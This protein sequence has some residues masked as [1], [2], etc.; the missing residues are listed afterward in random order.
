MKRSRL[1]SAFASLGLAFLIISSAQAKD[2][3]TSVRSRNFTVIGNASEKDIRNVA[4]RLEQFRAV[5]GS[6]FPTIPLNSAAPT[7]VIV[8]K[9]DNAFRPYKPNQEEAGYFQPGED[10][11][12]I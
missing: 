2:T 11:N 5:F 4:D 8:F 10:V 1:R 6:L 7:T 3:W 12:Y 9:N